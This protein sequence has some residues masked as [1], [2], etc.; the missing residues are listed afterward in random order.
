SARGFEEQRARAL[1]GCVGA[2]SVLPRS[3]PA[4]S[5]IALIL[6]ATAH[7]YGWPVVRGGT[8]R[9]TDA[10]VAEA[11]ASGVVIETDRRIT[12]LSDLPEARCQVLDVTPRQ[13]LAL[14][15][16]QLPQRYRRRLERFRY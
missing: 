7:Q 11:V 14:E 16:A 10:L 6:T 13:L 8:Q 3:A 12:S 15:G 4:S 1:R 9:L 5:A 2:P